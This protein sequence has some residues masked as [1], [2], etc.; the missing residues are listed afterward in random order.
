MKLTKTTGSR[1]PLTGLLAKM[2]W[3]K[4]SRRAIPSAA[5]EAD[6]VYG[7]RTSDEI[8]Q[9]SRHALDVSQP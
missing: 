4:V 5:A 3:V 6:A 8:V 7:V 2:P 9:A 1:L